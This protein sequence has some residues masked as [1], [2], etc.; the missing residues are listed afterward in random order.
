MDSESM[1]V[2]HTN[3]PIG[4]HQ[5]EIQDIAE[6]ADNEFYMSAPGPQNGIN[7]ERA[8]RGRNRIVQYISDLEK[9][10]QTVTCPACQQEI[11]RQI[12]LQRDG[13][14]GIDQVWGNS[15]TTE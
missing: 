12:K 10:R 9:L 7:R 15:L 2:E 1:I 6:S 8:K 5:Q 11:D 13:V 3:D 4:C 14:L